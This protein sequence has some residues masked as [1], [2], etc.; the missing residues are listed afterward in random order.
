[1]FSLRAFEENDASS[2][3]S[4]IKDEHAFRLWSADTYKDYPIVPSDVV[5]RYSEI[6]KTHNGIV[7]PLMFVEDDV[8]VG[9]LIARV[10][11]KDRGLVRFGYIIVDTQKRGKGYGSRMLRAALEFAQHKLDAR[12]V[13]LGVFEDNESAF[14]CYT[15]VG[16]RQFD[17]IEYNICGDTWKCLEL[18]YLF[19]V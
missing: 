2:I 19:E 12:R 5:A 15:A 1:M 17:S 11:D 8:T 16:F 7:F 18:E 14:R 13:T 10:V 6:R 4:W 9:H 3:L